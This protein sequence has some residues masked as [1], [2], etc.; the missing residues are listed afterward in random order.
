MDHIIQH[1]SHMQTMVAIHDLK[2]IQN[3]ITDAATR[4]EYI[5]WFTRKSDAFTW[6]PIFEDIFT[7]N[8]YVVTYH[9]ELI[10]ISWEV[11]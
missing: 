1:A 9:R 2:I 11:I 4:G 7:A 6:L 5:L 8:G 10:Y 3:L